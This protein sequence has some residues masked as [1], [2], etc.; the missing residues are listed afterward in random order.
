MIVLS[1]FAPH[2]LAPRPPLRPE[3]ARRSAVLRSVPLQMSDDEE[4]SWQEELEKVLSP[5]TAQS[6][7]EVLLK[8]L[9]GRG[10]E[11]AKEISDAASTG[12]LGSLIPKDSESGKLLEDV[13]SV[14]RQVVDDILPQATAEAQSL[15][16]PDKLQETVQRASV[17]AQEAAERAPL[18]AS[19]VASLLQDPA[20]AVNLVQQE[21]RNTFSRTPEG[22]ETPAYLVVGGGEQYELREY[23]SYGVASTYLGGAAAVGDA[24]AALRG[25]N[26]LTG[27]FFG[28]NG[29]TEVLDMTTPLRI[30]VAG[31]GC[32]MALVLPKKFTTGNA[33]APVDA[34][35]SLRQTTAQ[36]L[37]VRSFT[38]FAT[39]GEIQRQLSR[40]REQLQRD[41]LREAEYGSYSILQYNPPYTLPWLRR[42]EI[43]VA[44]DIAP[45]PEAAQSD[46]SVDTD[47]A[48]AAPEPV[49]EAEQ[50]GDEDE[51]LAPSDIAE[52]ET[53]EEVLPTD[54]AE[55]G[56][57]DVP[58][59]L[60]EEDDDLAPSD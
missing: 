42:N 12:S 4:Y 32:E 57:A 27:F 1:A 50:M 55:T 23:S 35:V 33:P 22:L 20:R 34:K 30:D 8:D 13:M 28:A 16:D 40:L 53:A 18:A 47:P 38:G 14:Q 24:A 59:E 48:P 52:M 31:T 37:A 15:L 21:A 60:S 3:A 7:R 51:D 54:V 2:A 49:A 46:G 29:A 44:V 10:P 17:D 39:D 26:S 19:A 25:F 58:Y 6:D 11:I 45:P 56:E 41:C 9:L 36:T 5:T 43:A